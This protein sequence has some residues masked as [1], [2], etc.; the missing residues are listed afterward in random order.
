MAD[1]DLGVLL[2]AVDIVGHGPMLFGLENQDERK[3]LQHSDMP[4]FLKLLS[5]CPSCEEKISNAILC[6][7]K[8]LKS[9]TK[10][11]EIFNV[12]SI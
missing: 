4:F 9:S 7:D 2:R 10:D 5:E 1:R 6:D 11:S 12:I 8:C 3:L